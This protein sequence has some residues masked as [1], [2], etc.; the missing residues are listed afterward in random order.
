MFVV[1]E[2]L[3]DAQIGFA[4]DNLR[5]AELEPKKSLWFFGVLSFGMELL[6]HNLHTKKQFLYLLNIWIWMYKSVWVRKDI[7][8]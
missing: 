3:L 5:S 4:D 7:V 6:L 8:D 1:E 2:Q